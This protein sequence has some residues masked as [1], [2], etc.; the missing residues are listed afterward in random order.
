MKKAIVEQ[1]SKGDVWF[2]Y[3][4]DCPIC[5]VAANGLKIK[6]AVGSLH[7]INAR[8]EKSHPIMQEVNKQGLSL[9]EGMIIKFQNTCYH[10]ADALQ[11]MALLGTNK[12]WF[13]RMNV[14]LFRS[15]FLSRLFY[16]G[17]RATRNLLLK[18]KGVDKIRNLENAGKQ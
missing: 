9:D 17:M 15:K 4:G 3:D 13:N 16:P 7:L 10:G 8:K 6:E 2:V 1:N 5:N 18:V 12:G 11:I 14:F